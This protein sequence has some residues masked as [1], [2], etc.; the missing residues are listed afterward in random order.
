MNR[1]AVSARPAQVPPRQLRPGHVQ[2]PRHPRRDRLQPLV[3]HEHP[4][5]PATG[6][7]S[8]GTLPRGQRR[9]HRH[10]HRGLGRPVR[11]DQPPARRPPAARPPAS[12]ASPAT[13]TVRTRHHSA[14]SDPAS[15]AGGTVSCAH[16][17]P[18]QHIPPA[19]CH[20]R[21]PPTRP[22]ACPRHPASPPAPTPTR[23]TRATRTAAPGTPAPPRT[24]S[25]CAR[26]SDASPR[27]G[28]HHPLR[29]PRG[30]RRVDHVRRTA[31]PH[32]GGAATPR[33]LRACRQA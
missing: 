2:L 26:A 29:H 23:R 17:Q 13:T 1:S 18:G 9:A 14:G 25:A 24:R 15:T 6:R 22:P 16:P 7:P 8:T 28:D 30:P 21:C 12:T 27:V 3:Q 33:R 31:R 19:T 11:V 32:V 10:A 4:G 5:V 20:A